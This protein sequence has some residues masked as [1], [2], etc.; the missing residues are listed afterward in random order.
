M[1]QWTSKLKHLVSATT[2][3]AVGT[4]G[5]DRGIGSDFF[6]ISLVWGEA[7]NCSLLSRTGKQ[8][9]VFP[10]FNMV[11]P[12]SGGS[13]DLPSLLGHPRKEMPRTALLLRELFRDSM[14]SDLL[15]RLELLTPF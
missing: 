1:T 15:Y 6:N 2:P 10:L 12:T 13:L 3:P 7:A 11:T 9:N 8:E 5:M 4:E 14:H